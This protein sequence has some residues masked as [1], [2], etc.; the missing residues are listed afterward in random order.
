MSWQEWL[1]EEMIPGKEKELES[2][3]KSLDSANGNL[4]HWQHWQAI[5]QGISGV[6]KSDLESRLE[7]KRLGFY[8]AYQSW[9]GNR[10][11]GLGDVVKPTSPN[12][13]VYECTTEGTSGANE[14]S[15]P[16]SVGSTVED[17]SV[18]WTCGVVETQYGQN[19]GVTN[20]REWAIKRRISSEEGSGTV[21]YQYMGTGWDN[22]QYIKKDMDDWD[23]MYDLLNDPLY[24]ANNMVTNLN[25]VKDQLTDWRDDIEARNLILEDYD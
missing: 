14:P 12:G 1:R 6:C 21:L 11:Y 2:V 10:G 22:D 24:G 4:T 16:T 25:N 20:I 23:L 17:G 8:N 5:Y 18:V 7:E 9:V 13:Y 3:Q 15:W 19:Y